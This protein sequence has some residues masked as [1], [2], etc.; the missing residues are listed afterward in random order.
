MQSDKAHD[1]NEGIITEKLQGNG[2]I[3]ETKT[4]IPLSG[5]IIKANE[6]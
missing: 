4:D 5:D 2:V 6:Y 1:V 3:T